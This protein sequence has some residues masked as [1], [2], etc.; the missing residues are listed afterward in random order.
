MPKREL[1]V[2]PQNYMFS[3]PKKPCHTSV[4]KRSMSGKFIRGTQIYKVIES[5]ID[6]MLLKFSEWPNSEEDIA[7]QWLDALTD[8]SGRGY[9][10]RT[11]TSL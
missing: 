6:K 1:N 7:L 8:A 11:R 10:R 9:H 5:A 4:R 2:S 3:A